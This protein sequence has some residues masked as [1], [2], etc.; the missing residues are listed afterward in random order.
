MGHVRHELH[1]IWPFEAN[2]KPSR[3][4]VYSLCAFY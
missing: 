4:Q 1:E 2:L 3:Q